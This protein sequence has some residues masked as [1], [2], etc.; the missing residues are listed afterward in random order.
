[1]EHERSRATVVLE[2]GAVF[3]GWSFAGD[4]EVAG[5]VVFTTSMVG[6]Q[7]TITTLR[8][9]ARSCSSPTRSSGTTV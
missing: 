7:E 1:L 4:G 6:Y 8:T 5:E 2:D 9:A 3:E